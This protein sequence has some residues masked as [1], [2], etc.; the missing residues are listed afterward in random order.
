MTKD[1]KLGFA[2]MSLPTLHRSAALHGLTDANARWK[3]KR[4]DAG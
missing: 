4:E 3:A 1:E 2:V